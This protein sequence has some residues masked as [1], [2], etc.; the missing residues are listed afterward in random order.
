[1]S[2][3]TGKVE[4]VISLGA[5]P[6]TDAWQVAMSTD[7]TTAYVLA[8]TSSPAKGALITVDLSTG[9]VTRH[10]A[11]P[12]DASGFVVSAIAPSVENES[13][14]ATK[15]LVPTSVVFHALVAAFAP[16]HHV[17]V[18]QIA[19]LTPKAVL[20]AYD[21]FT[22]AYW[23]EANFS[24]A[25]SD[26]MNMKIGFQDA[27]GFGVFSSSS[28]SGPWQYKGSSLPIACIEDKIVPQ[29]VRDVWQVMSAQAAGCTG[30]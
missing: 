13:A 17:S 15:N 20:Y 5:A 6:A 19:S 9:T 27:G 18:S 3:A 14:T 23:S 1:V 22:K 16:V 25:A 28:P 11:I 30:N 4:K 2:I 26:T 29:S 12:T 24:P 7:G 10:I 8:E 21:P